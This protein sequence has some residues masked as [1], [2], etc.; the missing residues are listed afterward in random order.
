MD[1]NE[2]FGSYIKKLRKAKGLN[3]T[4]VAAAIGLDSGGLSKIE[5]NKK[6][7]HETK[8]DLLAKVLK[9]DP[10]RLKLIFFSQ[11]FAALTIEYGCPKEV[12]K[13]AEEKA[14]YLLTQVS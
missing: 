11:K 5:T 14:T 9:E 2:N 7:I 1:K 3:Q 8:L 4:Q 12:F 10:E 6:K 13:L